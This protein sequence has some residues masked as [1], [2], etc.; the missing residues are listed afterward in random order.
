MKDPVFTDNPHV[1]IMNPPQVSRPMKWTMYFNAPFTLPLNHLTN[2][3]LYSIS[4]K[5]APAMY[6][7]GPTCFK[8]WEWPT[9]KNFQKV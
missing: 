3:L 7:G 5:K 9:K 4:D 2:M 8:V 6:R 1:F